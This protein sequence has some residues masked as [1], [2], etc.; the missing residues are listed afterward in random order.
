MLQYV[1]LLQ[2]ENLYDILYCMTFGELISS[3]SFVFI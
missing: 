1:N 2:L 3:K